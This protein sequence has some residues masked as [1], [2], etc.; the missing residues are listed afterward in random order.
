MLSK[1]GLGI[2]HEEIVYITKCK[3]L[4]A[5]LRGPDEIITRAGSGP[6][7]VCWAP[8]VYVMNYTVIYIV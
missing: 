4:S 6:R 2:V 3:S 1:C 8:L 5:C 7:A